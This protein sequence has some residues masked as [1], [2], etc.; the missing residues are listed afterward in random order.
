MFFEYGEERI[1]I[2][3]IKSYKPSNKDKDFTIILKFIDNTERVFHF[4]DREEDRNN[5][6]IFLDKNLLTS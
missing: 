4:F 1:N 5:F 6:L 3:L 2:D